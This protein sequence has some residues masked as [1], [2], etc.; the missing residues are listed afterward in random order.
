[1]PRTATTRASPP[2]SHPRSCTDAKY[3]I[4]PVGRSEIR[5]AVLPHRCEKM[6]RVGVGDRLRRLDQRVFGP[7][8]PPIPDHWKRDP[9]AHATALVRDSQAYGVRVISWLWR[10]ETVI[11]SA[12]I[13]IALAIGAAAAHAWAWMGIGL[14]GLVYPVT[15]FIDWR[16][17]SARRRTV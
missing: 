14:V 11:L 4:R 7:G 10:P 9:V 5:S 6:G 3:P 8:Q 2:T 12:S 17:R 16:R 13:F 1:M 15:Y